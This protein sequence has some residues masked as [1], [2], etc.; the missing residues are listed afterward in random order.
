MAPHFYIGQ[1]IYSSYM[2]EIMGIITQ[3][4]QHEKYSCIKFYAATYVGP[5]F[6]LERKKEK[7][8][9]ILQKGQNVMESCSSEDAAVESCSGK[10]VADA[11]HEKYSR[12]KLNAATINYLRF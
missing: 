10:D 11:Q 8:P 5:R 12:I 4:A 6:F 3:D 7:K 1:F 2:Q 9:I